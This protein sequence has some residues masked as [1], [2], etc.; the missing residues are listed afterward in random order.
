MIQFAAESR[1]AFCCDKGSCP[2][3]KPFL[4]KN[5]PINTRMMHQECEDDNLCPCIKGFHSLIFFL[6]AEFH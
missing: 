6:P 3:E 5:T 4:W 2:V 1:V